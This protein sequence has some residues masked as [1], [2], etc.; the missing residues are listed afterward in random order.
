[1]RL[2]SSRLTVCAILGFALAACGGDRTAT[3][4]SAAP[5][6]ANA[7]ASPAPA[8]ASPDVAA[9]PAAAPAADGPGAEVFQKA[10]A[11]CH[12]T[13]GMGAPVVGNQ[14]DWAPRIAKGTDTLYQHALEGFVGE[15]G[16]MPARGG[17]PALSDEEV[18]SA[19]DHMVSKAQ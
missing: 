13:P 14:E 15:S 2:S 7:E 5:A 16:A 8:P 6:P 1:M 3:T 4:D 12:A 10:C 11:L 18:K 9:A 17:N 19:V